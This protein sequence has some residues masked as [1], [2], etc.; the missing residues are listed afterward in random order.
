MASPKRFEKNIRLLSEK[1]GRN[2]SIGVRKAALAADQEFVLRTPVLSGRARANT[3]IG[4]DRPSDEITD[5][6]DK[7]GTSSIA[8]ARAQ[9]NR[10]DERLHSEIHITNNLPYIRPLDEGSSAQ[11]PEGMS[12]FAIEAARR[13]LRGVRILKNG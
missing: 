13:V 3:F 11:A 12:R 7:N 10:F 6:T 5:D 8:R 1:L 9:I 2:V 4:L